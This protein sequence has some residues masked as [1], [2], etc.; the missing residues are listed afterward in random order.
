MELLLTAAWNGF[1]GTGM[2]DVTREESHYEGTIQFWIHH[3]IP[4]FASDSN[5]VP[6]EFEVTPII[7]P[8]FEIA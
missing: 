3:G 1:G 7:I 5:I 6:L 8:C 2:G 4:V